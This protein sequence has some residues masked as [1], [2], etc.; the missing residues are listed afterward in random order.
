MSEVVALVPMHNICDMVGIPEE[1][2]RTIAYESHLDGWRDPRLLKGAELL[3]RVAQAIMTVHTIAAELV[4]ARRRK[5]DDLV[6]ALV[7]CRGGR[8]AAHR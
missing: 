7:Q 8:R 4:E 6:T 5:P 2:R 3:A 1:H